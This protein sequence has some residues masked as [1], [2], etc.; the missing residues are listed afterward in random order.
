[1]QCEYCTVETRQVNLIGNKWTCA[2]CGASNNKDLVKPFKTSEPVFTKHDIGKPMVSLVEPEF[3][4][5]IAEVL[6]FGTKKYAIDNWKLMVEEDI[7]RVKDS[8]LRHILAYTS[9]EL[10]DKESGLSHLQHAG[11]NLMFLDYHSR[12][13][14]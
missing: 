6:T 7:R 13:K 5:G 14:D 3:I 4:L 8:L 10:I 11:C 9:G 2:S 1:M 12:Q